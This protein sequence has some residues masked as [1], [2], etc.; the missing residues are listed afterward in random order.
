[1]NTTEVKNV[2]PSKDKWVVPKTIIDKLGEFDLDVYAPF[3]RPWD[4]AKSHYTI[5]D[6]GMNQDWRGRVFC[7][8]PNGKETYAWLERCTKHGN[9][10]ALLYAKTDAKYFQDIV[11]KQATAVLFIKGRVKFHY[12]NGN[13]ADSA[14]LPCVLV[15]F[16]GSNSEILGTC[17][18]NGIFLPLK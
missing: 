10:I 7:H 9:A 8:P 15:A 6:D 4:T 14:P 12:T 13:K 5:I 11:L 17:G 3:N 16:N 18:I 1:M 2:H